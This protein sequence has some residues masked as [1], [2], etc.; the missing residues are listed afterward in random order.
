[1][2]I[3]GNT[4]LAGILGYPVSH[5][6]S[7]RM[8][9]A[10]Y[11]AMEL[12]ICYVPIP[13]E[14]KNLKDAIRGLKVMEFIGA[15]VTIPHKVEAALMMDNLAESAAR[16]GAVNTI[17]NSD[18]TFVGHNTDGEGF[19][20][21]LEETV[22]LDYELAP[23]VVIGAGG[24]A[25]SIAVALAEA[26]IKQLS[27]VNR[28]IDRAAELQDLL[29]KSY[30]SVSTTVYGL[31]EELGEA[32]EAS[33]LIINTTPLGMDGNL[34]SSI[35][36]VDNLTKDH[37]VC[38]TVYT[39]SGVT[40]MITAAREKRATT[41]GGQGMLLHQGALAIRLWTGIDPPLEVMRQ[42]IESK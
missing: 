31:N 22:S 33:K 7:P 23:A 18:G 34:K 29:R 11:Q 20:R 17:V 38:D 39:V 24:A 41:L 5:S 21:S 10:A 19:I 12:D 2:D 35:V 3:S 30:P 40:P 28:S 14:Q 9:N 42:A 1:M 26:G 36:P 27:I 6:L 15:N 25:R 4:K 32:I 16:T 8:H 13:V 37:V